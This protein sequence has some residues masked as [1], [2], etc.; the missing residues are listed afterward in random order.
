[1]NGLSQYDARLGQPYQDANSGEWSAAANCGF[2][3]LANLKKA[4]ADLLWMCG[5][6]TGKSSDAVAMRWNRLKA[7]FNY[8]GKPAHLFD[9]EGIMMAVEEQ[10]RDVVK[11]CD[12]ANVDYEGDEPATEHFSYYLR[13]YADVIVQALKKQMTTNDWGEGT[14]AELFEN[15]C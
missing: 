14:E 6:E 12:E 9:S 3:T 7:L 8:I 4:T 11:E 5:N 10:L 2:A 1:M 13:E 15:N